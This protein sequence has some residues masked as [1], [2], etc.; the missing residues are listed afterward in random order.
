[1]RDRAKQL[2][3]GANFG[4][5]LLAADA[6]AIGWKCTI[7]STD[8]RSSMLIAIQAEQAPSSDI[9]HGSEL[10]GLLMK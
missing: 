1:L 2:C 3:L 5:S 8:R 4:G 7:A 10:G 9:R 6:F